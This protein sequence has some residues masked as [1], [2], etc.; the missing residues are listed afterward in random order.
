MAG[1]FQPFPKSLLYFTFI[2]I[3]MALMSCTPEKITLYVSMDG[4]DDNSGTIHHPLQSLQAAKEIVREHIKNQ[5]TTEIEIQVGDG[6]YFTGNPMV[7]GSEDSGNGNTK[8]TWK[9]AS[10]AQVLV[11]GGFLLQDWEKGDN[12]HW[13]A[14]LPDAY[15]GIEVREMFVNGERATRARHP[16]FDYL[17]IARTGSDRRTYFYYHEG[18]FPIPEV[19][20]NTELVFLHDWSITRIGLADIDTH[21]QIIKT[22]DSI[23][24]KS[25]SF[26]NID[27]WEKDPRYFLEND[28][29]FLD[30][31]GEWYYQKE[32]QRINFIPSNGTD[33]NEMEIVIPVTGPHLIMLEGSQEN[34]VKN[35]HFEGIQFSHCAWQI[36]QSGYAG[37]QAC[38]FDR[39]S[40]EPSGT[41]HGSWSV[42]PAAVYGNW[43]EDCSFKN[44]TF[45]H[46]GGSGIWLGTGTKTSTISH[47]EF[48]DISGNAIMLGEGR[49]RLIKGDYWW[50]NT[51]ED[52]AIN[53]MISYNSITQ[54]GKQFFGAVGIWCGFV[55]QADIYN[56]HIHT[57]PYTGISIGWEWSP[58]PTPC[59]EN[60][61]R[62]NHIHDV[63][64]TLSD[65]GGIYMLGLQ[66]GSV[67][68]NNL[69]HDV[70]LNVGRAESNGMFLDE[71]ATDLLIE[72]NIIY[73]IAKSPLRFHK[74]FKN[75]VRNNVLVMD[76]SNPAI[77]YN[78]TREEDILQEGNLLLYQENEDHQ[79]MLLDAIDAWKK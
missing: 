36:P 40:S 35:I 30:A 22:I 3:S 41:I 20:R 37:I 5:K 63:M 7:F 19:V 14:T 9:A 4:S 10:D 2:W 72:N 79:K 56:N 46:L 34:P 70:K 17:R 67:I 33:P 23:G 31:E 64:K 13:F 24:A 73:N 39:R 47:S 16:N 8:V 54:C 69:I 15:R 55:A 45:S 75:T 28:M 65:G 12:G 66:P 25:L 26:F 52:A 43:I 42:V 6:L 49:E 51:P 50:K 38:Y 68:T 78:S 27:H 58:A 21:N 60:K 29:A 32:E 62:N 11:S 76:S 71:G 44:C 1:K 74:A 18:D 57:L 77:R 53:N 59:R 61:I 48:Y